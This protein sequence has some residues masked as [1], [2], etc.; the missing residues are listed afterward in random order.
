MFFEKFSKTLSTLWQKFLFCPLL[1]NAPKSKRIAYLGLATAFSVI[2]NT[3]FEIKL[4]AV[5]YS[6]TIAVCALLGVLMG[7]GYGFV[8]CFVGDAIGF[9]LHPFG[10]Y[11]PWVGLSNGMIAV[12]AGL[13]IIE[14]KE[15]KVGSRYAM[16]AFFCLLSFAICTVGITNTAFFFLYAKGVSYGAYFVARFFVQGQIWSCILNYALIFAFPIFLKKLP[17]LSK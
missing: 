13:L 12:L 10:A 14:K 7:A 9:F 3:F 15:R 6:F 5:Q 2:A 16:I 11:L 1:E 4:G 17:F 8:A